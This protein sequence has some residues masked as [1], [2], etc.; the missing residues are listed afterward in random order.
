MALYEDATFRPVER[1]QPGGSAFRPDFDPR[2]LVLH[3]AVS[4]DTPS[5]FGFFDTPG[6]ATPHFYVG[7]DGEVEQYIG[8]EHG[9]GA[10]LDG[11]HDCI[12][13]ETFDGF[14][15]TWNG[16]GPGPRW[17]DTQVEALAKLAVWCHETHDIPLE[18]LP[19]S[20]PGSRGIGWHRQGI[21]GNFPHEPGELLGGRVEGGE[22]WSDSFGKVCPTETRIRQIVDEII[23]RAIEIAEGDIVTPED[24]ELIAEA[25]WA[26]AVPVFDGEE[27]ETRRAQVV[28][29]QIHNRAGQ[30]RE[31]AQ[32]LAAELGGTP[33]EVEA[34]LRRVLA[35]LNP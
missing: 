25:V 15:T 20:L 33:E 23:P 5:M 6:N 11:N 14:P 1:Y 31:I 21:D 27:G 34:A 32:G 30:I 28:L 2:R 16:G 35:E 19:S 26:R 24:I 3:T 13:V 17:T 7:R 4:D 10:V 8:T 9:S 12:T 29:G 18:Q 22:L